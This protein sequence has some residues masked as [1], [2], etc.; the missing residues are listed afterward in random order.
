MRS[1]HKDEGTVKEERSLGNLQLSGQWST[2]DP[3]AVA[4]CRQDI[5]K[6]YSGYQV[7]LFPAAS[8]EPAVECI[9]LLGENLR[10]HAIH[11]SSVLPQDTDHG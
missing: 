10:E 7:D 8:G 4:L 9:I 6:C 11:R 3:R 5:Y 1:P 2:K